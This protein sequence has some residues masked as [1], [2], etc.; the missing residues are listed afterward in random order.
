V[1]P[2]VTSVSPWRGPVGSEVRLEGEGFGKNP[3]VLKVSLEGHPLAVQSVGDDFAVV[4][5]T[6]GAKSGRLKVAVPLQGAHELDRDFEVLSP[7]PLALPLGPN[8]P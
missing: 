4:R 2:K 3:A 7:A 8:G 1:P 5:I 6:A